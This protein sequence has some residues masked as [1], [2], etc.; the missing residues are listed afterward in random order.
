MIS[1]RH[2]PRPDPEFR[3]WEVWPPLA[4][5]C[6]RNKL[7]SS[8]CMPYVVTVFKDIQW[9]RCPFRVESPDCLENRRGSAVS[10]EFLPLQGHTCSARAG[11][12]YLPPGQAAFPQVSMRVWRR[13]SHFAGL[14]TGAETWAC[15]LADTLMI[16]RCD[17]HRH[18]T[19]KH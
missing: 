1:V 5:L 12:M 6:L 11:I 15:V 18:V 13:K 2:L 16:E 4:L 14:E 10:P 19:A 3:G 9:Q 17:L 7:L 8:N